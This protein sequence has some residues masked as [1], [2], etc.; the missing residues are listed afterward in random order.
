VYRDGYCL[1]ANKHVLQKIIFVF[2]D[3][4]L[5]LLWLFTSQWMNACSWIKTIMIHKLLCFII[6]LTI[7]IFLF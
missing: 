7:L 6:F 4:S 2:S 3:M 1:T 5:C